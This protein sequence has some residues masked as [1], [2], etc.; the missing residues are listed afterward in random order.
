[1][2]LVAV[3]TLVGVPLTAAGVYF[4]WRQVQIAHSGRGK[5]EAKS[6]ATPDTNHT[7]LAGAPDIL[8]SVRAKGVLRVGCLWYPPF[9]E[10]T[11][12]GEKVVANG[13]Y[14]S[15]IE[16]MAAQ[17]GLHV[18]YQ[19]LRWD[20]AI[21]AV[22]QRQVDIA[23]CVLQSGKRRANCDFVGTLYRVG[24]GGVARADSK[25][26]RRHEDLANPELRIAVTKGEIGWEYAERYLS[27]QQGL[28]RFTVV[29]DTQITRMM[30]LVAW[31]DVDVA[32]ADSLSCAQHVE[33]AR[34]QGTDLVDVFASAPLHIEDNSLMIAK[35]QD[36]LKRWLSESLRWARA[37]PEVIALEDQI[38]RRYPNVLIKVATV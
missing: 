24:V 27:L 17:S 26:I 8:A 35:N 21:E 37:T 5:R 2:D 6:E 31:H 34:D 16:C 13:L 7:V 11:Q 19:I 23:A 36:D 10:F 20:T 14:P 15:M 38:A 32:L 1:M 25:K 12:Q 9:V 30:N 28:S 33:R 22:N 3:A 18:E 4:G 29:E